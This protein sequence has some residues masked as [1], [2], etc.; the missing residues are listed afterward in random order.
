MNDEL[1]NSHQTRS[2]F[3][4]PRSSLSFAVPHKFLDNR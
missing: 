3:L 2:A 1:E 4:V